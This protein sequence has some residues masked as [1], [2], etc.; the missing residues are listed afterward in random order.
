MERA[1]ALRDAREEQRR[2]FVQEKLDLQWRDACDDARALDS[3]A[4][5]MFM[6]KERAQ[7]IESKRRNNEEVS[8]SENAFMD[9]WNRQLQIMHD[10]DVE[11]RNKQKKADMDNAEGLREQVKRTL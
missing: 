9:E 2:N 10:K 8:R 6:K 3:K 11:K 5:T 4:L 7:Q 1:Y